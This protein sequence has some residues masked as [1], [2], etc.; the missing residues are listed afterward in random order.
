MTFIIIQF[1][2][3]QY[4]AGLSLIYLNSIVWSE[5]VSL[6]KRRAGKPYPSQGR[7]EV[8]GNRDQRQNLGSIRFC[9]CLFRRKKDQRAKTEEEPYL[10]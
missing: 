3:D 7:N 6:L 1:E 9:T 10:I 8:C 4:F 5:M 2:H